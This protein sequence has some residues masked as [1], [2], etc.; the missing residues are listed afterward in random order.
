MSLLHFFINCQLL[1]F[2]LNTVGMFR[3]NLILILRQLRSVYSLINLTGLT[4]GFTA[5]IL[6]FLWVNEEL[7]YD[8]FHPDHKNTFRVVGNM[9]EEKGDLYPIALTPAPLAEYLRF[10]FEEIE[11]ACRL[12]LTEFFIRYEDGGFYVVG[13]AAD[14][15][16]FNVFN[17][18][19]KEGSLS[20]F[21]TGT[22]KI[23]IS[24]KM[25]E[26]FFGKV[27][28]IG[29]VF[30][31]AGRDVMVMGVMGNTPSN[32]HLQFDYVLPIK[33]ME[34]MGFYKLVSWDSF[35]LHTYIKTKRAS[36]EYDLNKKIKNLL[37]KN[38]PES[39]SQLNL[40]PLAN[41]HLKSTHLNN[42]MN[43]RGNI[44]YVYIFSVIAIFILIVASINYSN[45]ATARSIKRSKETGVRKVMGANRFQLALFF[46]SESVLYCA[47]AL[48]LAV[49]ASWL[50][51]PNFNELTGKHLEFEFYSIKIL[52]PLILSALL[53]ALIG[54]TYPALMLP[55]KNPIIAFKGIKDGNSAIMLRRALVVVQFILSISLLTGALIIQDQMDYIHSRYLGYEKE[56]VITF[57]A[58]KKVRVQYAAFKSE[59]LRLPEVKYVTA[60]NENIAAADQWT[61]NVE[62]G[63]KNP[64]AIIRFFILTVDH[65]FLKTYSIE[66]A[67][68]RDF[69]ESIASDSLAI[70]INEKAVTEM[71]LADPLNQVLRL[72]DK[73]YTIIGIVKDFHFKS[74]HTPV[75]PLVL[76]I[77]PSGFYQFSVKLN[78]GPLA[79][80]VKAVETV[81]K[82]FAPERPFDYTFIDETVKKLYQTETR[83]SAIFQ[84]FSV[85]AIFI[86]CLGLVGIISFVTE[87][88]TRELAIRKTLGAP[89]YN[90]MLLLSLEYLIMVVIG[91][92]IAL[93][94]LLYFSDSWLSNFAYRIDL[95]PWLFIKAGLAIL[96]FASL[97]IAYRA[98]KAAVS[99]PVD[100][101]RSE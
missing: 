12:R 27:D 79:E 95:N 78:K 43:G 24:Q 1:T 21:E 55:S 33:L 37:I 22:D 45:L 88:R 52:G 5:F 48:S 2:L 56:N 49:L 36:D 17:F 20:G 74:I 85:L 71:G 68:G 70:L 98:Y 100:G 73:N 87:Q 76:Y 53:C 25:A 29:K 44:Q 75:A 77:D 26:S 51:L 41:I 9:V 28:P 83:T 89:V 54:G 4:V 40:Q 3:S 61:D 23:I 99:N 14:P 93:P 11:S 42:E 62:W 94:G 67:T 35:Q 7:S 39:T 16:F 58:L 91:Y 69:S 38:I 13:L 86:S 57:T 65:D 84:Y 18:P 46:F 82:K 6:I 59:L 34:E 80:H 30:L 31:I 72:H 10:N 60:N 101:L 15:S 63:G 32:S 81:A 96:L 64:T 50:L 66:L 90:L 19:L 47:I 8:R 92:F 97:T